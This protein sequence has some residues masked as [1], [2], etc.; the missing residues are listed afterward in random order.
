[1][2]GAE[3]FTSYKTETNMVFLHYLL[4]VF[5]EYAALDGCLI[6]NEYAHEYKMNVRSWLCIDDLLFTTRKKEDF[7]CVSPEHAVPPLCFKLKTIKTV[8][9]DERAGYVWCSL[10]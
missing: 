5:Y 2:Y 8:L 1:M 3:P 6:N 10:E 9:S 7:S 4:D